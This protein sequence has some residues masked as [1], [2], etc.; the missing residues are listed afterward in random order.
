MLELM[1][2]P[3]FFGTRA[4]LFMDIVSLIVAF[5]PFIM[6]GVIFLAKIKKYKLHAL[7]QSIL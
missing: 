6:L 4:P 2:L 7:L 1:N 5:L 3:G